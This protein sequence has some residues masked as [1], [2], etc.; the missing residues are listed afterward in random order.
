MGGNLISAAQVGWLSDSCTTASW[1]SLF[2]ATLLVLGAR[3]ESSVV[4]SEWSR[5]LI[6][7]TMQ[8]KDGFCVCL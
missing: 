5:S 8:V 4:K 7:D 1:A 2:A 3:L 6:A